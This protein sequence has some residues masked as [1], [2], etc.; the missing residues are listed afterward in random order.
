MEK[1]DMGDIEVLELLH[2]RCPYCGG[3][4]RREKFLSELKISFLCTCS[5]I[6]NGKE[7]GCTKKFVVY[8]KI[9]I[10]VEVSK[11]DREG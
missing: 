8:P 3:T 7:I 11:I 4:V 10:T 6:S 2:M 1:I 5:T 9:N